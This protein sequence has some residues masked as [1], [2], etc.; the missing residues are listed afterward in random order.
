MERLMAAQSTSREQDSMMNNF[1]KNAKKVLEINPR[2]PLIEGLLERVE[3]G[4]A[5][6]DEQLRDTVW[7]LWDTA[8]VRS[9]FSLRDTDGC[10][11]TY[12]AKRWLTLRSYFVRV[13]RLLRKSIGVNQE[14]KVTVDGLKAAPAVEEGPVKP[15]ADAPPEAQWQDW[16]A[17]K[18]QA[19]EEDV[20]HDEL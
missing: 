11:Q 1:F 16:S 4:D 8:L 17:M 13:E 20:G 12:N 3:A 14:A 9:G 19:K 18:E 7:T 10:V 5:E 15:V 2:H 6:N